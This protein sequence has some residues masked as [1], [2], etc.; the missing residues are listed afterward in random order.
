MARKKTLME[1]IDTIRALVSYMGNIE[2]IAADDTEGLKNV[3]IYQYECMTEGVSDRWDYA[4]SND[5]AN[6]R[7]LYKDVMAGKF[8]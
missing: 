5:R 3:V 8:D 1:R 2:E 7:R 6:L 4:T